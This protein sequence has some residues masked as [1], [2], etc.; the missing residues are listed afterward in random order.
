MRGT[1][2][3]TQQQQCKLNPAGK[4]IAAQ[5]SFMAVT[6]FVPVS[7]RPPTQCLNQLS[8]LPTPMNTSVT[9][10]SIAGFVHWCANS[11]PWAGMSTFVSRPTSAKSKRPLSGSDLCTSY[12]WVCRQFPRNGSDY[13]PCTGV[14]TV[15]T[16]LTPVMYQCADSVNWSEHQSCTS[17]QTVWT[18]SHTS[19]IPVCRQRELVWTPVM[20][21][22]A[23]SVN[24]CDYQSYTSVQTA[25]TGLN[26][27]HVPVC[28]QYE[29]MWLPVMY[30]CADSVNW[31]DYQSCT[32]VQTVWTGLTTSHVPVC[33]QC[34]LVWTPVI[35]WC[36][37]SALWTGL[38]TSH[39]HK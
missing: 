29:L 36:V 12:V 17:V 27:S 30:H 20:Y 11:A 31:Y 1:V 37:D 34:E 32:G 4:C 15:W 28:R 23:D 35:Y 19:H 9:L 13:Q 24:W 2:S 39:V 16:G 22:C 14:Q 6:G 8:Y 18:G 25:W 38:N 33:R 21:Q 7:P 26:T 3:Y 5:L 10:W